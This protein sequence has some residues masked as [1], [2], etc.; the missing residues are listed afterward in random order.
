MDPELKQ[1]LM[2]LVPGMIPTLAVLIAMLQNT[3]GLNAVNRR[4]DDVNKRID[5]MRG[6]MNHRFDDSQDVWRAELH[7]VEEILDAR[8][9]HLEER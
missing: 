6:D 4:I 3:A 7:R 8:L 9:K 2:V 1:W 5:D